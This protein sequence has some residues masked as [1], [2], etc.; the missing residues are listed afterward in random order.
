MIDL[1]I[2]DTHVHLWDKDHLKYPWLDNVPAIDRTYLLDDYYAAYGPLN[3]DK[4][5]FLQCDPLPEQNLAEVEWVTSLSRQD[6]RIAGIVAGGQLEQG[7]G[8]R[9][10]LETL[11][12]NDLMRGI[13]RLLHIEQ[14]NYF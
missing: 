14:A 6:T 8:V 7:E 9:P 13:R 11:A 1:P 10:Y 5:V 3:I 12:R 2:V 4:M